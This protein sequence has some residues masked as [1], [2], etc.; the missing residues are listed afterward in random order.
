VRRKKSLIAERCR[1]HKNKKLLTLEAS[2]K[3]TNKTSK[4]M[5][6]KRTNYDRNK[7]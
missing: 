7:T 5:R 1:A 6:D 4:G 3:E 2:N